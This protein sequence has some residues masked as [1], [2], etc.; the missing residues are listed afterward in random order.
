MRRARIQVGLGLIAALALARPASADREFIPTHGD[1]HTLRI[2][3]DPASGPV[4]GYSVWRL[5]DV[6]PE[7][8]ILPI[9]FEEMAV[10]TCARGE[11]FQ[12]Q[13]QALSADGRMSDPSEPS[14][15]I[16]CLEVRDAN[17]DGHIGIIDVVWV[18]A[19][20]LEGLN[21]GQRRMDLFSAAYGRAL[22]ASGEL[23]PRGEVCR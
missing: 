12:M 18:A 23:L 14:E 16:H 6:L 13:V 19:G 2:K 21:E 10:A 7:R 1:S 3:W 8:E 5:F 15:W 22:C 11:R 4:Q 20:F 9:V 17:G